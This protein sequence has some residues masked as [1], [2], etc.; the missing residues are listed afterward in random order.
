MD[1]RRR[2][3]LLDQRTA[4]WRAPWGSSG[5]VAEVVK[6]AVDNG[7]A[8]GEIYKVAESGGLDTE[9]WVREL[10]AAA[11]WRGE[12]VTTDGPSFVVVIDMAVGT[13]RPYHLR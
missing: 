7:S 8:N 13:R 1:D 11:G 12:V 10:G 4:R 6:I 3:I 5:D 2:T 9:S